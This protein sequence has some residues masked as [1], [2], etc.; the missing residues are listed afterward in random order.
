MKKL[1]LSIYHTIMDYRIK[2]VLENVSVLVFPAERLTDAAIG[3]SDV[4]PQDQKDMTPAQFQLRRCGQ[5]NQP[6]GGGETIT[7]MCPIGVTGRYLIV[8]ILG[9]AEYLALCEVEA[10]KA[11]EVIYPYHGPLDR[12][13]KLWVAHAPGMQGMFSPP[14]TSK[15]TAS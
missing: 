14:L 11:L 10:G 8:Q 3:V 12:Y 1:N 4:E 6:V 13:V 2:V 9:R 15:E 5:V 7:I